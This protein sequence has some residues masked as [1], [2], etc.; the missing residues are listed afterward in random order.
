MKP[1]TRATPD[2][3]PLLGAAVF[4]AWNRGK[5]VAV[6]H[7]AGNGQ[8]VGATIRTGP[9]LPA[10]PELAWWVFV[11]FVREVA[12]FTTITVRT[13][14]VALAALVPCLPAACMDSLREFLT[15]PTITEPRLKRKWRD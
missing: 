13:E 8:Y 15:W 10:P 7:E 14:P 11:D 12:S 4:S 2:L 9:T 6:L 3:S 1:G 5:L